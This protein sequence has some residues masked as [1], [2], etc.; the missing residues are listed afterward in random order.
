MWSSIICG[1]TSISCS[2]LL[3]NTRCKSGCS[4]IAAE[5]EV[6]YNGQPLEMHQPAIIQEGRTL[7]ALRDMAEQMQVAVQWDSATRLATVLYHWLEIEWSIFLLFP[8]FSKQ[9]T[10]CFPIYERQIIFRWHN[11][12]HLIQPVIGTAACAKMRAMQLTSYSICNK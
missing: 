11:S 6:Y 4:V 2:W 12:W 8:A 5:P 1:P 9:C 7:F 10:A 3:I